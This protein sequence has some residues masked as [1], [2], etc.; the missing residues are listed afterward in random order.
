MI[1]IITK[2]R[3]RQNCE[4]NSAGFGPI[5][6]TL[7]A[8]LQRLSPP[9]RQQLA[10]L[11]TSREAEASGPRRVLPREEIRANPATRRFLL[12]GVGGL[13]LFRSAGPNKLSTSTKSSDTQTTNPNHH[14]GFRKSA[15]T[16]NNF[17]CGS[18]LVTQNGTLV[19]GKDHICLD[20]GS[21][22]GNP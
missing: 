17:G 1:A 12:S 18:N 9:L 5:S 14:Q 16:E 8:W 11:A 20:S 13:V 4:T 7:F 22:L 21:M 10:G 15:V 19:R 3:R 2:Q 6:R